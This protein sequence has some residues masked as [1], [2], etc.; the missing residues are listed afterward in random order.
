LPAIRLPPT[1]PTFPFPFA[2]GRLPPNV[3][4]LVAMLSEIP[5]DALAG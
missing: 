2:D 1:A 4:L 5:R 3:A